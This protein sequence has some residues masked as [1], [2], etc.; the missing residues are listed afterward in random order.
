M[1][2]QSPTYLNNKFRRISLMNNNNNNNE[3]KIKH[4]DMKKLTIFSKSITPN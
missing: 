1:S 2:P 3:N 4:L